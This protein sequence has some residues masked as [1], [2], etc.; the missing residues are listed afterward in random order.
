MEHSI[1]LCDKLCYLNL[2]GGAI[3]RPR[4]L[5]VGGGVG[6]RWLATGRLRAAAA[7]RFCFFLGAVLCDA[8]RLLLWGKC[9]AFAA[10]QA[11][12]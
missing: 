1:D 10:L 11:C 6:E 8:L 2:L 12:F 9:I 4:L 3:L 5:Y 7:P